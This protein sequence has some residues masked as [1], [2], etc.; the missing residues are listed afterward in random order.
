M[1]MP[2]RRVY[3]AVF[4]QPQLS[5]MSAR[6]RPRVTLRMVLVLFD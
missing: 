2:L 5:R 3:A 4:Q 1:P 6:A